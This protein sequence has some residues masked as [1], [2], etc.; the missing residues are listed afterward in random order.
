MERRAA[1]SINLKETGVRGVFSTK[2][3]DSSVG[4]V[5]VVFCPDDDR[6]EEEVQLKAVLKSSAESKVDDG[7]VEQEDIAPKEGAA[8]DPE[9]MLRPAGRIG[10]ARGRKKFLERV[11][12]SVPPVV[13]MRLIMTYFCLRQIFSGCQNLSFGID[14]SRIGLLNRMFGLICRPDGFAGWLH[15]Q[16][17]TSNLPKNRRIN[18]SKNQKRNVEV[19]HLEAH[20][21]YKKLIKRVKNRR[22]NSFETIFR[23]VRRAV[24]AQFG[25][26]FCCSVCGRCATWPRQRRWL[27]SARVT[28]RR[29]R[30][31]SRAG[32]TWL[33]LSGSLL[34]ATTRRHARRFARGSCTERKRTRGFWRS[35]TLS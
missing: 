22:M 28:W 9:E 32:E 14:A 29:R 5:P 25:T 17:T 16:A 31:S 15:P 3:P 4:G 13:T 2:G 1:R 30:R 23:G 19:G 33:W 26:R 18:N 34:R 11:Q 35:A 21:L 12:R 7:E 6:M 10:R 20:K 24:Q 27:G 8:A